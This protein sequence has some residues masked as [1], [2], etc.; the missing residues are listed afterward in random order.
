MFDR[1]FLGIFIDL[2][3]VHDTLNHEILFKK[4]H[5]HGI[6]RKNLEDWF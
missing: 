4:L 1:I 5:F 6:K 2:S 3:K